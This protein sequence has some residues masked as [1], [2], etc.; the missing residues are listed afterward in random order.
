MELFP[1]PEFAGEIVAVD[2]HQ[3]NTLR[4]HNHRITV[5]F[6]ISVTQRSGSV[7]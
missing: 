1:L 4:F 3:P 6:G 7:R 2:N 5:V